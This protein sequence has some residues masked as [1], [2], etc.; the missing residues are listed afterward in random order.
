MDSSPILMDIRIR[1]EMSSGFLILEFKF[2]V[3]TLSTKQKKVRDPEL[4]D[5][6]KSMLNAQS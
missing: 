3:V 2:R 6:C 5:L 4:L 1:N